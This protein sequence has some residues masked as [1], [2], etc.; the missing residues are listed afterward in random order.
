MDKRKTS[1][2]NLRIDSKLK[3]A[4]KFAANEE[5]R[6]TA[7]MVEVLIIRHCLQEGH[8]IPEQTELFE[9]GHIEVGQQD[10]A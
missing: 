1:S 4:L 10:L 8:K 9:S 7:N 2:L 5:H 6:S 3:K